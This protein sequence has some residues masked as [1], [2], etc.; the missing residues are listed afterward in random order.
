MDRE[1]EQLRRA[2]QF[3]KTPPLDIDTIGGPLVDFFKRSVEKRQRKMG[4][5]AQC[6]MNLVPE[7]LLDHCCMETFSAGTLTILVDSSSHL[8]ELKGL[9]LNGLEKQLINLCK[10]AGL[11]RV[12]L[13]RGQWYEGKTPAERRPRF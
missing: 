13:K 1:L 5:I 11:R 9:L 6:L 7:P 8:Y 12:S 2:S 4:T 10:S 3:K